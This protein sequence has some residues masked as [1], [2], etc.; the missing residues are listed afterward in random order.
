MA[1]AYYYMKFAAAGNG[2][3]SRSTTQL[4]TISCIVYGWKLIYGY[5]FKKK[6]AGLYKG[7]VE[8]DKINPKVLAEHTGIKIEDIIVAKWKSSDYDPGHYMVYDHSRYSP[9]PHPFLSTTLTKS[10]NNKDAT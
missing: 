9:P 4:N 1:D 3:P 8:G 2:S 6:T 5:T 10:H 7:F